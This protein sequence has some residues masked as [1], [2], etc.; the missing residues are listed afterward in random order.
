M[1]MDENNGNIEAAVNGEM[2]TDWGSLYD[3]MS[4]IMN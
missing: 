4:D 3:L 1:T 2:P